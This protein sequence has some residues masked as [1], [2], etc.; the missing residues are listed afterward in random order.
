V[1]CDERLCVRG[2]GGESLT[3][4]TGKGKTQGEEGSE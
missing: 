2:G 1:R 4:T 3:H